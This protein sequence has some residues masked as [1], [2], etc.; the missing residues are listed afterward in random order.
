MLETQ[1]KIAEAENTKAQA[2][3][4]NVQLKAEVD[5]GKN[6]LTA[7]K[8]GYEVEIQILEQRLAEA[9]AIAKKSGDAADRGL[10]KYEIDQRTALELTRIE[11]DSE[12][13]ENENFEQNKEDAAA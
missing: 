1:V 11:K 7:Q 4:A 9:E 6:Q 8:Q 12:K 3:A 13:E 2:Q 5:Q 10:R